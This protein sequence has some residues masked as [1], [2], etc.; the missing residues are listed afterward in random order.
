MRKLLVFFLLTIVVFAIPA[1]AD[2]FTARVN[3]TLEDGTIMIYAGSKQGVNIGDEFDVSRAGSKVG[4]IRVVRVKEMFAYCEIMDGTAQEMD[5][6]SRTFTAPPGATEPSKPAAKKEEASSQ[7]D[8]GSSTAVAGNTGG[9]EEMKGTSKRREQAKKDSGENSSESTAEEKPKTN[10]D[11]PAKET[12]KAKNSGDKEKESKEDASKV[13]VKKRGLSPIGA[14]HPTA[15]GLTGSIFTPSAN[16]N[17]KNSGAALIYFSNSSE[18]RNEQ[19]DSGIGYNYSSGDVEAAFMYIKNDITSNSVSYDG[20]STAFS[21]KFQLPM[22]KPPSFLKKFTDIRYAAGL[23]YFNESIEDASGN[24]LGGK[25][26]RFFAVATTSFMRG[27]ANFALYTQTGDLLEDSDYKGIGI[28]GSYEY[29][30]AFGD[31]NKE[32]MSL[33]FEGDSKAFYLNTYRTLSIGLRY[34]INE[35]G[36]L[37]LTLADIG[38]TNTFAFT[39]NYSF[40]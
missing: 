5:I 34:S 9:A 27:F 13:A 23:Q 1:L 20:N 30:L 19:R 12:E 38:S 6:V 10:E 25:V 18:K 28:M 31:K 14:T 33:I 32:Q 17:L 8:T 16:T 7:P 4:H 35:I 3:I 2:D 37:G 15:F 36:C 29:P 39:G 24:D 21:F 40:H 22:S 26:N 11:K